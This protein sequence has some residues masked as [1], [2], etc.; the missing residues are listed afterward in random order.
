MI[1]IDTNVL[2]A[3]MQDEPD[4]KIIA[5]LDD[6]PAPSIWTTAITIFEIRFGLEKLPRGRRRRRLEEAFQLALSEDLEGRVLPF[7]HAAAQTAGIVAAR[8]RRAGRPV[9]VRDTLIAAIALERRGT[10]ATR[11]LRHFEGI[12]LNLVDPWT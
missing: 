10:L 6:Q 1:V 3:V 12:G 9:D 5:W 7:D 11:N 4:Q 8:Q 2:S